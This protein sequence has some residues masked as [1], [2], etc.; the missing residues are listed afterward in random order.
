M[1]WVLKPTFTFQAS[2]MLNSEDFPD[3]I[4][5]PKPSVN[6]NAL[7]SHG[8]QGKDYY[9]WG[10]DSFWFDGEKQ[11][12]WIGNKSVTMKEVSDEIS[13]LKSVDDCL[14]I[15]SEDSEVW[16]E[17]E[18]ATVYPKFELTR[19]MYPNHICCK[20]IMQQNNTDAYV[21]HAAQFEF[22]FKNK[23]FSSFTIL[24][25]DKITASLF[26]QHKQKMLGDKVK[27]NS[28][29][30]SI[31]KIKLMEKEH[32]EDDPKYP[33]KN[34]RVRG[35]YGRCLEK[36]ILRQN[37]KLLN[38]TPPWMTKNEDLWCKGQIDFPSRSSFDNYYNFL[39]DI[40]NSESN[41]G[42]CLVPCK[43]K[44]YQVK[45]IGVEERME[46]KGIVIYFEKTVD[47][48]R[49]EFIIGFITIMSEIGGFI[50][51]SKNLLWVII[52]VLS[53]IGI[54]MSNIKFRLYH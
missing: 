34:Y 43:E 18:D 54:F 4:F 17:A 8:Y 7:I 47:V 52:L 48:T 2:R 39:E 20:L 30:I 22:S 46:T 45:L 35:E 16:S 49:T 3:M 5:C 15:D 9:N 40:T 41:P 37:F 14:L 10:V 36:E 31:F 33:C 53:T 13:V 19:A 11:I 27:P 32:V 12:G 29:G 42:N 1:Y 51:I 50:G 24:M 23:S 6:I 25:D 44:K 28:K 21:F 38:C 26:N